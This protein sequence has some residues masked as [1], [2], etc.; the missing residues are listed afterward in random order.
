MPETTI[1][2]W[3]IP[4][5]PLLG[6]AL[7]VCFGKRMPPRMAG[8]LS[9]L[10]ISLSFVLSCIL[11]FNLPDSG[12]LETS[13]GNWFSA[14]DFQIGFGFLI[15]HLSIIMMLVITGVGALIHVY[16]I[17]YMK[18]DRAFS[19]FFA[20]LNLFVF[21]M[22]LLVMSDNYIFLFAGW[23]GVGL[24]SYLL[25]GFWYAEEANNRAASKAFIMNRIGDFAMLL[26]LFLMF[27]YFGS[28]Q[29]DTVFSHAE[30][31]S[32]A[33]ASLTAIT[34]LLFIG[35]T[36]KSAQIPLYTWLPDAMAG[37][38]P[39]S[40]LIH[41]AT[42][43]TA[44]V[45]LV[46]RSHV[47]F[48]LTPITMEVIFITGL[49]TSIFA[50]TIGMK[51]NDIKKVLAW[52]TI[53]QLGL[54]FFALGMGAFT[55]GFFHLIT[56]AFFKGL[57]FL[58]AGSVI[59]GLGGEQDIRKMGGLRN[60][61]KTTHLV[62]LTG[63]LAI[64][65]LPPFSGFFSKDGILLSAF[66]YSFTGHTQDP[67]TDNYL[68]WALGLISGLITVLYMFRLYFLVFR[69]SSRVDPKVHAHESPAVMTI[70]LLVLAFLSLTGGLI[71]LPSVFGGNAALEKYMQAI[72][73]S[74]EGGSAGTE[75]MLMLISLVL[76]GIV[77]YFTYRKY[78][79][80]REVPEEDAAMHGSGKLLNRKYYVDELYN[81]IIVRPLHAL[82]EFFSL[83]VEK[84]IDGIVIGSAAGTAMLGQAYRRV[85][86]G[87]A[88]F[89]LFAIALGAAGFIV[90]KLLFA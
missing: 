90:F 24:C 29:F 11:F 48:A 3:L 42:M 77:I 52:S 6:F 68:L 63:T 30:A 87:N 44:G 25:I 38:T 35:A 74:A 69:G 76:I 33:S 43:V 88:G 83:G 85:Q 26:G 53:S 15:D 21:F 41:A 73:P 34:L 1:L 66:H 57:L 28:L 23:E 89:Y 84:L 14:G 31:W 36:G 55:A 65:A 67:H 32:P 39:V 22:L 62:F 50:G 17:G 5:L 60:S 75:T 71:N 13:L 82:S 51:Q 47:L 10:W 20:Y 78:V 12:S 49:V 4:G 19:T 2:Q 59:H 72:V 58:A 64:A 45:Y 70:P 46:V 80:L 27:R 18:G 79:L 9:S 16:S 81:A 8:V 7:M 86:N 40:A 56:H 54:M 61:M 37:P